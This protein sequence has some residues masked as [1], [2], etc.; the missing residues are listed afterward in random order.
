[1]N[2]TKS[3]IL[4]IVMGGVSLVMLVLGILIIGQIIPAFESAWAWGILVICFGFIIVEV[5]LYFLVHSDNLQM[6]F[7]ILWRDC[8]CNQHSCSLR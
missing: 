7:D 8:T 2:M 5:L 3:K 4:Q 6:D 1:M